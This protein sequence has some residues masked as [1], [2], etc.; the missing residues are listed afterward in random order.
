MAEKVTKSR[1]SKFPNRIFPLG[2]ARLKE[3]VEYDRVGV[4]TFSLSAENRLLKALVVK[5][6]IEM[7]SLMVRQKKIGVHTT[8]ISKMGA[9]SH[10]ITEQSC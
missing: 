10:F 1:D 5:R 8:F 6:S 9:N 4:K 2:Q 3:A 7:N